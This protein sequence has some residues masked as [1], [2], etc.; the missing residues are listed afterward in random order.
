M[1][2]FANV[3]DVQ[4]RWRTLADSDEQNRVGELLTEASALLRI[5]VPD[6]DTRADA[7]PNVAT[8]AKARVIDAVLRVLTNPDGAKQ[9]QEASGP[10]SRS[11][12]L[13]RGAASGVTGVFFNDAELVALQPR[14]A[15]IGSS[16]VGVRRSWAAAGQR[17]PRTGS[18]PAPG[19][20]AESPFGWPP[21]G[22]PW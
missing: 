15:E 7:D 20:Y 1:A 17:Y 4:T 13:D 9:L 18:D 16:Y 11:M 5:L 12:S 8:L 3:S 21:Y 19:S 10:F 14:V 6:I 2:D 22:R